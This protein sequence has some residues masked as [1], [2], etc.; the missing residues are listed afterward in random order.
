MSNYEFSGSNCSIFLKWL[1]YLEH[2]QD[3]AKKAGRQFEE[4]Y[5]RALMCSEGHLKAC[6][7][8]KDSYN[9]KRCLNACFNSE[10][11]AE[12]VL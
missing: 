5:F 2:L 9:V 7:F 4:A 1:I 3:K 11:L 6:T 8:I 10:G 12:H